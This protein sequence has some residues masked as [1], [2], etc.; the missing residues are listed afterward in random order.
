MPWFTHGL[1]IP[2]LCKASRLKGMLNFGPVYHTKSIALKLINIRIL[3]I[4]KIALLVHGLDVPIFWN[5]WPTPP[6]KI[7]LFEFD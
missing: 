2:I 3:P 1:S 6:L 7:L 5:P 4:T